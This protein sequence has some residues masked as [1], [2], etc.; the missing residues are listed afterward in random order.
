MNLS[1]V[2]SPPPSA[3]RRE[4]GKKRVKK[5]REDQS[6]AIQVETEVT[7]HAVT[8]RDRTYPCL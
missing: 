7:L 2:K 4:E 1:M 5:V 6:E 8:L 3:K